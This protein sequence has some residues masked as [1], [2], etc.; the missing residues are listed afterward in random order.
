MRTGTQCPEQQDASQVG[1]SALEAD[2]SLN[3]AASRAV[4][5]AWVPAHIGASP[6]GEHLGRAQQASP[7]PDHH[8]DLAAPGYLQSACEARERGR[9]IGVGE[10]KGRGTD[11]RYVQSPGHGGSRRKETSNGTTIRDARDH[12]YA[13]DDVR[14]SLRTCPGDSTVEIR[15][16]WSGETRIRSVAAGGSSTSP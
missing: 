15:L 5:I 4:R 12:A 11:M 1:T 9:L 8:F 16:L 2:L 6:R 10:R 7:N 3:A 14:P 13:S